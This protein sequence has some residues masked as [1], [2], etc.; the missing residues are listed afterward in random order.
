MD[1]TPKDL[2]DLSPMLEKKVRVKDV[3]SQLKPLQESR[4]Y[5]NVNIVTPKQHTVLAASTNSPTNHDSTNSTAATL[6][7]TT[8]NVAPKAVLLNPNE[9]AIKFIPKIL[10][11]KDSKV[12]QVEE[13]LKDLTKCHSRTKAKLHKSKEEKKSLEEEKRSFKADNI[14]LEM[15]NTKLK[16]ENKILKDENEIMKNKL[17]QLRQTLQL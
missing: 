10:D 5:G 15:S 13:Q 12:S 11:E 6:S 16:D 9:N 4:N 14:S 2:N 1:H 7:A 17:C 8:K 3:L